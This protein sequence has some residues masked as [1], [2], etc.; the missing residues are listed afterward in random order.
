MLPTIELYL[1]EDQS[2]M[3]NHK[4][5]I[6]KFCMLQ[7]GIN[8]STRIAMRVYFRTNPHRISLLY[9]DFATYIPTQVC[10]FGST[11]GFEIIFI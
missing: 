1:H 5:R 3:K 7:A 4:E 9:V 11:E 6:W 2:W 8:V 10:G